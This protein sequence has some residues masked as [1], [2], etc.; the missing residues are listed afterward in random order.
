MENQ[1]INLIHE[2]AGVTPRRGFFSRVAGACGIH[3]DDATPS[4]SRRPAER[5]PADR[6]AGA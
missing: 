2:E 3:A 1:M 4:P 6:G 5:S